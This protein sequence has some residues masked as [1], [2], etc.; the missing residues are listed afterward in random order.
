MIMR[1]FIL[2][3]IFFQLL[4]SCKKDEPTVENNDK[5]W[6]YAKSIEGFGF[7]GEITTDKDGFIYVAAPT[8]NNQISVGKFTNDGNLVWQKGYQRID[9]TGI[10]TIITDDFGSIYISGGDKT[11][12]NFILKLNSTGDLVWEKS[13]LNKKGIYGSAIYISNNSLLHTGQIEEVGYFDTIKVVAEGAF[14]ASYNLEGKVNWVKTYDD[15]ILGTGTSVTSDKSG[16]ILIGGLTD[17]LFYFKT[18]HLGNKIWEL[19]APTNHL[20]D[21]TTKIAIDKNGNIYSIGIFSKSISFGSTTLI[22]DNSGFDIYIT[23]INFGGS[24]EWAKQIHTYAYNLDDHNVSVDEQGYIYIAG[25]A[26]KNLNYDGQDIYAGETQ[27]SYIIKLD[28]SGKLIWHDGTFYKS[29]FDGNGVICDLTIDKNS[30]LIFLGNYEKGVSFGNELDL[31]TGKNAA[32]IAKRKR[33]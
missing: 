10:F 25:M 11:N 6:K 12:G 15:G 4:I 20:A 27:G 28:E 33:E 16:N 29:T 26:F 23:K 18:N 1:N 14:L 2:L 24:F 30:D 21:L 31:N 7:N 13:D 5:N 9:R 8:D 19:K 3:T 22:P 17:G 32:F